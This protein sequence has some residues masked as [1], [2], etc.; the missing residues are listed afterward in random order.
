MKN[1]VNIER[2]SIMVLWVIFWLQVIPVP[3][4][5]YSTVLAGLYGI[6]VLEYTSTLRQCVCT[7]LMQY[8][9]TRTLV[10]LYLCTDHVTYGVTCSVHCISVCARP[11][12]TSTIL[13]QYIVFVFVRDVRL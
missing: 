1:D 5:P 6:T 2:I 3:V 7:V 12:S 13:V 8:T 10:L 4:V 11:Y 9:T